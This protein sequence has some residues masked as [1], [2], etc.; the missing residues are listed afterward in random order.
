MNV[1]VLYY[2]LY[3]KIFILSLIFYL[4][5]V[6]AI[7]QKAKKTLEEI[8]EK[9]EN[10]IIKKYKGKISAQSVIGIIDDLEKPRE[11]YTLI[12]GYINQNIWSGVGFLGSCL[13]GMFLRLIGSSEDLAVVGIIGG[14]LFFFI[15]LINIIIWSVKNH[16]SEKS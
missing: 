14:G 8:K 12:K 1:E 11:N 5:N 10:N 7:I 6:F 15:T 3:L 13:F 9:E 16:N 4:V 2:N